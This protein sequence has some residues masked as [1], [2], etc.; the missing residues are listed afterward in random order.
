MIQSYTNSH[1]IKYL[2]QQLY[3]KLI[4]QL[5]TVPFETIRNISGKQVDG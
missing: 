3:N 2:L 4:Q 1:H 5:L